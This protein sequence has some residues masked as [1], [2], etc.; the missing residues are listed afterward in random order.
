MK[1][2]TAFEAAIQSAA[3]TTR[4]EALPS[5]GRVLKNETERQTVSSTRGEQ[6]TP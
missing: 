5:N 3:N 2:E 4:R 1:D 6:D